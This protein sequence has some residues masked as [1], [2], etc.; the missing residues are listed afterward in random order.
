MEHYRRHLSKQEV[1]Y[2]DMYVVELNNQ[3][4]MSTAAL[5]NIEKLPEVEYIEAVKTY[6]ALSADIQ[7]PYQWSL[8]NPGGE[9]G[10][11]EQTSITKN[12]K[13]LLRNVI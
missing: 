4:K 3:A 9:D 13:T 12:C 10:L 2:D 8:N 5:S 7:S 6:K 11:R 1:L